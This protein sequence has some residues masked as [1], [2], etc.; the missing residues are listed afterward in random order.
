MPAAAVCSAAAL[1]PAHNA[2]GQPANAEPFEILDNSFLVEEAF[3]QEAGIFQN[4]F[5]LVAHA[6]ATGA[7]RSRRSGRSPSQT[8]PVVVHAAA[9]GARRRRRGVGDVMI[10]YRYQATVEGPGRPGVFTAC[11]A[12]PSDRDEQRARSMSVGLQF[13]LPFSKQTR[14]LSTSTG[15]PGSTWLPRASSSD[16][17]TLQT[18]TSPFLAGSAI[19]RLRPMFN[20]MLETVLIF[21]DSCR[22][23]GGTE[24]RDRSRFRR[25]ARRLES[26]RPRS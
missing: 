22:R 8:A 19:Y 13:N 24:R 2:G 15:T 20:L 5:G 4:I 1:A 26:R 10:N 7:S 14:R 9:L 23:A 17:V 3:N 6:A 18:S 25:A 21:E 11:L 12:D 16:G